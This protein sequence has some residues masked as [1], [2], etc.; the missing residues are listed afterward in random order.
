MNDQLPPGYTHMTVH[1][2]PPPGSGIDWPEKLAV[3]M[4]VKDGP[5]IMLADTVECFICGQEVW[6]SINAEDDMQSICYD[7]ADIHLE[8]WRR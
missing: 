1:A 8:G 3:R 4:P 5:A 6:R 7:C 2:D